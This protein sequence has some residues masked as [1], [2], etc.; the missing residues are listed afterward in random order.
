VVVPGVE[1]LALAQP[2]MHVLAKFET[3]RYAA[4]SKAVMLKHSI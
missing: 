2:I 1:M 3:L 4:G